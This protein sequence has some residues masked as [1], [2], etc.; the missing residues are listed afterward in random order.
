MQLIHERRRDERDRRQGDR[1]NSNRRRM[2]AGQIALFEDP[3]RIATLPVPV[4]GPIDN[5]NPPPERTA[6]SLEAWK[7]IQQENY[8]LHDGFM[9][10]MLG[11]AG[12]L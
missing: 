9:R 2:S 8:A 3:G 10:R 5:S 7:A 11:R 12:N 6:Q 1:R 4:R